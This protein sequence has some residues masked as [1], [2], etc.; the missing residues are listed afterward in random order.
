[1]IFRASKIV[2]EGEKMRNKLITMIILAALLAGCAPSPAPVVDIQAQVNEAVAQTMEAQQQQ[3][4]DM[5]AQTLAAQVP[6]AT[7]TVEVPPTSAPLVVPTFTALVL[8]TDTPVTV[9]QPSNPGSVPVQADYSCDVINR[10]PKDKTEIHRGD[11]FDIKWTI[12]NT[13]KKAWDAGLDVSY[14]SGPLMTAVTV[15]EIPVKMNP[16]ATYQIILDAVA[17]AEKGSQVMIWSV[18][19]QLCFP[20][21]AIVVK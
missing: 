7:A 10:R 17:P 12:V 9:I 8:P 1:M 20:Y 13:G 5:V 21:T 4:E 16:G 19:G 15:V 11:S 14:S 6:A 3:V 2:L 18:Q